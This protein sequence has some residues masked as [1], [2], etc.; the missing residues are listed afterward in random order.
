MNRL[1]AVL[2]IGL[3]LAAADG[4]C[5]ARQQDPPVERVADERLE[6]G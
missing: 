2:G 3:S 6:A 1:L 4:S 5:R